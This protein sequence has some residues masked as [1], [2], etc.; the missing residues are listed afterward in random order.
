MPSIT[1]WSRLEPRSRNDDISA[2][3][4]ARTFDPFW[5]LARQ[6]Q[7]GEMLGDD[8]GSPIS[9]AVSFANARLDRYAG[10]DGVAAA[11]PASVPIEA[12]VE[13]EGVR[14]AGSIVDYHQVAEAGLQFLRLLRAAKMDAYV[15]AYTTAYAITLPSATTLDAAAARTLR[16]IAGRVPDGVRLASDLRAA[17]PGLPATPAIP[18]TDSTAVAAVAA[19]YLACYD[20]LFD[21]PSANTAWTDD[22]MEYRFA[23]DA[24]TAD[25]P[26]AFSAN[27]YAGDPLSWTSF[28]YSATPL[29]TTSAATASVTQTFVPSPVAF[30]GM[31][32]RRFWE[33]EDAAIDIGAIEAGPADLGRLMV[34]EFALIYGNDWFVVPLSVAAGSVTHISGLVVTDTFG[35]QVTV[36]HYTQTPDGGKWHLFAVSGDPAP[37]RLL[38]APNLAPG[39]AGDA[40][41]QTILMRDE[42]AQ[43]AWGVER[44]VAGASGQPADRSTAPLSATIS[45]PVPAAADGSAPPVRYQLGSSVPDA[46]IPFVPVALTPGQRLMR[47]AAFKRADGSASLVD[48]L[49]RLLSANVPVFEEEFAREGVKIERRYRLARGTDGS[50]HLWM[51]RRKTIGTTA[52]ASGLAF[53]Q[54]LET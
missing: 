16:I 25:M 3:L 10:A 19:A 52:P 12:R 17:Q 9:A 6:W 30:K 43:M 47:R 20:A 50:T 2:G 8:A 22:R 1:I 31:P 23:L 45:P 49:G 29:G 44:I 42:A 21:E 32:A 18:A 37:H 24:S 38:F 11:I 39:L 41:E 5:M 34:R 13:A 4:A 26:G 28:D 7:L 53:D 40:V 54:T 33:M 36:P 46:Y 51:A 14:P 27:R 15:A 48:P 35:G